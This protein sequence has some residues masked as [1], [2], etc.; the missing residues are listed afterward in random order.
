MIKQFFKLLKNLFRLVFVPAPVLSYSKI[1]T[2]NICPLK[3]Y[4]T[5]IE[6]KKS[7]PSYHLSY[8]ASVHNALRILHTN[9]PDL[10]V[11]E[12]KDIEEL[13]SRDDVWI[14]DGY[15]SSE[16]EME[17][18]EKALDKVKKY[19]EKNKDFRGKIIATEYNIS[20]FISGL[21][22]IGR[23]DRIEQTPDGKIDVLDYKTGKSFIDEEGLKSNLQAIIYYL[24]CKRNWGKKFGSFYVYYLERNEMVR[25]VP[26]EKNI[27]AAIELIKETVKSIKLAQYQPTPGPLCSWC[28]FAEI[29]P[30]RKS[31][32]DPRV[33]KRVREGKRLALSYSK[34]SLYKNCPRNYKRIYIDRI[35][36]KPR[37]FFAIG[38]TIHE[39]M[40]DFYTYDGI[41]KEPTYKYLIKRYKENW[42][43]F[44]YKDKKQEEEYFNMGLEWLEK[45]YPEFAKGKWR[46]AY[47]VEPYFEVPFE[48]E[49]IGKGHLM[50]GFIDRIEENPDGTFSIYDYKTDPILRTQE[51]V[52]QD[53]QLT[54]YYWVCTS[55]WKLNIRDL[56]LEF[57]RFTKRVTTTRT[58]DDVK[59]MFKL[60]DDVGSQMLENERR[61]E[62]LSIEEADK[63]FPPK[64]NKYCG[65]CD[66]FDT[67]PLKEEILRSDRSKIMNISEDLK[68]SDEEFLI[69][70][71]FGE[72]EE[73]KK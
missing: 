4:F 67:C 38:L 13:L 22:F 6:K 26:E 24:L 41:R 71:E 16:Q 33:Y 18:F 32:P 10:K 69:E 55:F 14:R 63:Y 20:G 46:R 66:H 47:K 49:K 12:E 19:V 56:S 39:T 15:I 62:G 3:Y 23:L 45:W 43:S 54:I 2:F 68:P 28:D 64:I 17:L 60:I 21:K 31:L 52:D 27:D 1:N 58:E 25:F 30:E 29:C 42:H 59:R 8:G 9:F 44:G 57:L 34:F 48:G 11:V 65:G 5:Y 7:P 40:E 35:A 37:H 50:V 70:E 51:E 72:E 61:I 36:P 73:K 53:L